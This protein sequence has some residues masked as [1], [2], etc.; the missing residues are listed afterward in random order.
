M[1]ASRLRAGVVLVL[2]VTLAGLGFW[3]GEAGGPAWAPAPLLVGLIGCIALGVVITGRSFKKVSVGVGMLVAYGATFFLGLSSFSHA[4]GECVQRGEHVRTML[5]EYRH[6]K[7]AYP[8]TLGQLGSSLPCS[9]VSGRTILS[10]QK[11][12]TGYDLRFRDWLVEHI[13]T[14]GD[15]FTAH[16]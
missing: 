8:E 3:L 15:S 6:A 4:F 12:A 7:G 14:E 5:N 13:A 16:K 9:R 10:Y 11:T 2:A 1:D